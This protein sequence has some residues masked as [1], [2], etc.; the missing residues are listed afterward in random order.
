[1]SDLQW[2]CIGEGQPLKAE[3]GDLTLYKFPDGHS[4]CSIG[5]AWIGALFESPEAALSWNGAWDEAEAKFRDI[6]QPS[7]KGENLLPSKSAPA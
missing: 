1:M 2:R 5:G 6:N 3:L 4:S 7:G